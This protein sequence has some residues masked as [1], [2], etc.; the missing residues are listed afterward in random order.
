MNEIEKMLRKMN[1]KERQ[2]MLLLMLQVKKNPKK[3]PGIKKL[4]GK[5]GL[6]RVRLGKYRLIFRISRKNADIVR[7]SKRNEGTYRGLQEF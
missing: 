6:F 1:K 7:I 5:Y 2:A 3:V 4:A